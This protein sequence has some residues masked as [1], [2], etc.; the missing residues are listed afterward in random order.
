L[1]LKIYVLQ[2]KWYSQTTA[3]AVVAESEEEARKMMAEY[4][5]SNFY[6][7]RW[8]DPK[9]SICDEVPF[10]KGV[11]MTEWIDR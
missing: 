9:E 6:S 4:V 3:G 7:P 5:D 2:G 1:S 8:L 10:K 11:I